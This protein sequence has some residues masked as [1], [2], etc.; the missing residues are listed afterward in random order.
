MATQ[1]HYDQS[2][3]AYSSKHKEMTAIRGIVRAI[4]DGVHD[5]AGG[6]LDDYKDNYHS[7]NVVNASQHDNVV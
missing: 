7:S 1:E 2:R 3:K 6:L 5:R 4:N